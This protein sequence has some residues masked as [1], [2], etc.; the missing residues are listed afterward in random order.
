MNRNNGNMFFFLFQNL[1]Y[2]S[3]FSVIISFL[4]SSKWNSFSIICFFPLFFLLLTRDASHFLIYRNCHFSFVQDL[5]LYHYPLSKKKKNEIRK[6]L[7]RK[8]I[9]SNIITSISDVFPY[10][11][12]HFHLFILFVFFF[13]LFV[14][15]NW[16]Y[17]V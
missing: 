7:H 6:I 14:W 9:V 2:F 15:Y 1:L 13:T 3:I 16:K 10:F 17:C 11:P 8:P 12:C 5:Y 4:C